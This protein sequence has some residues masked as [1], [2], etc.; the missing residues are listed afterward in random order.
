MRQDFF[1]VGGGVVG[2]ALA[3]GLAREGQRVTL[4]DADDNALRASRGN[5]GLT[6][7]QGKGMGMPRYAELSLDSVEAWPAFA[8]ELHRRTG[9]DLEY[10]QHGGVD[11]CL[12]AEEAYARQAE[13]RELQASSERLHR[14]F[15]WEYL[16]RDA[17]LPLLPGL[18]DSVPGGTWSPHDGHCNPLF[19]LRAL[20]AA[21]R[22]LGVDIRHASPVDRLSKT[23][24][25]F[26][27]NLRND[28]VEAERCIIA[29]G[30]GARQLAPQLGLSGDVF[31]LRGQMLITE[32]LP[33]VNQLPTPQIRQTATGGYL[34]G[35][36]HE[37]AGHDKGVTLPMMQTL[38]DKAVRI[39][40]FLRSARLVRAW[41]ALRVMTADGY[42]LYER[43][44]TCPGAY[45]V[46][47]HSGITLAAFHAD[48]LARAILDDRLHTQF[49]QFSGARFH[50]PATP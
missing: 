44:T 19:L 18:G 49:P 21:C 14:E 4:L 5:A 13:Y 33:R 15:R 8:A 48:T 39:F 23:A 47:C 31:P 34:I 26:S 32:R 9:I 40:P 25:G 36:T 30:L 24:S 6:W 11:L 37:R 2:T 46:N 45:N 27:A 7:V 43:S 38:A 3:Y 1:I 12:D 16:E 20:Y 41:G 50:V 22:D 10:E 35:D 29:A 17:L 42:P 28:R